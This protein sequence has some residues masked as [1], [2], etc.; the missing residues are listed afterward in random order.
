MNAERVECTSLVPMGF[1]AE[2]IY[3]D[4]VWMFK[5]HL[6]M[7]EGFTVND[8]NGF[9]MSKSVVVVRNPMDSGASMTHL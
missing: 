3:D 7:A 8:P 9:L 1:F 2:R 4:R 5:S 6:P